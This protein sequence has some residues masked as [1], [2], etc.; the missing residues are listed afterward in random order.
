MT[1]C[2]ACRVTMFASLEMGLEHGIYDIDVIQRVDHVSEA[3]LPWPDNFF[4]RHVPQHGENEIVGPGFIAGQHA[5][6]FV[7]GSHGFLPWQE[8]GHVSSGMVA[9]AYPLRNRCDR[10][11]DGTKPPDQL[12]R[13]RPEPE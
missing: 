12:K 9:L 8:S 1:R 4:V 6:G 5:D 2:I 7:S 13:K 3:C 11:S 10:Y